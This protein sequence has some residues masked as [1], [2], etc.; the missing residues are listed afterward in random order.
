VRHAR[1]LLSP[2][3]C[4]LP[5]GCQQA[6]TAT[7]LATLHISRCN[8]VIPAA[9]TDMQR[10]PRLPLPPAPSGPR[11][12]QQR[13]SASSDTIRPAPGSCNN[14][15][16]PALTP[17]GRPQGPAAT[18]QRQLRH[19]QAGPRVLQ[20]RDSSYSTRP[21]LLHR[22]SSWQSSRLLSGRPR[23]LTPSPALHRCWP[24]PAP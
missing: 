7:S 8:E 10:A 15:T 5:S 4:V 12:L 2:A 24:L 3:S 22:T 18:G 14:G 13:D 6:D 16:A 20:Q 17:S 23:P 11:V 9:A 1:A 21:S 19:H